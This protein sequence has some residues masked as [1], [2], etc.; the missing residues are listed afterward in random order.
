MHTVEQVVGGEADR[1]KVPVHTYRH[2][3]RRVQLGAPVPFDEG[4]DEPLL[5][6]L[7]VG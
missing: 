1:E 5:R 6:Q 4:V 2:A 3:G 7:L